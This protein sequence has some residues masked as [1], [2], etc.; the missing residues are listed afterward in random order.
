MPS[1]LQRRFSV[2]LFCVGIR[3]TSC[4][5]RDPRNAEIPIAMQNHPEKDR[6][7][8]ALRVKKIPLILAAGKHYCKGSWSPWPS[9]SE[10]GRAKRRKCRRRYGSGDIAFLRRSG[11]LWGQGEETRLDSRGGNCRPKV[12]KRQRGV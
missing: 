8:L 9:T 11:V 2:K 7:A 3:V 5:R 10:P 4:R 6:L 1:Y 12:G